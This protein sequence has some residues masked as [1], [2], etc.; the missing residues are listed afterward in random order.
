MYLYE[1]HLHTSPVSDCARA[2][3]RESLEF[4]K[5]AGYTGVFITDHFIDSNIDEGVREHSYADRI[6]Y[7]FS[8]YNE[9]VEI[10]REIGLD[11]F[12]GIEMGQGWAHILVYGIDEAWCLAHPE[13]ETMRKRELLPIL[14]DAGAILV[15]AHPFRKTPTEITL[16]PQFV[17]G[18]EILN[19]GRGD[20]ENKLA[21]QFCENY[22]LI[23]CA[24][25]DN[26]RAGEKT[27]FGGIA[28]DHRLKDFEDFKATFLSGGAKPFRRNKNGLILL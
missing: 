23:P 11:V 13:M 28:T 5:S 3:V 19:T 9:G 25:S 17:H 27:D 22:E 24:G 2:T 14:K 21:A 6:K 4:Y 15:Q 8:S 20:F 12:S 7:Y 26:H 16:F 1:T 18:V 10:G